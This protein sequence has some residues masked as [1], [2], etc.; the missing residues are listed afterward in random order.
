MID[1]SKIRISNKELEEIS[2]QLSENKRKRAFNTFTS[3]HFKMGIDDA[4]VQLNF[5]KDYE[6]WKTSN[7]I[8]Y[9]RGRMFFVLTNKKDISKDNFELFFNF[10]GSYIR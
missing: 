6:K 3:E 4:S 8:N 9:E 7:Q 1:F 2:R 5:R 10:L